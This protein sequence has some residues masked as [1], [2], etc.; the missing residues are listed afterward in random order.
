[1]SEITA[2]NLPAALEVVKWARANGLTAFYAPTGGGILPVT[3]RVL[4]GDAEQVA[5]LEK[6]I[7]QKE[8]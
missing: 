2:Q 3:H 8:G 1:M 7:T 4:V 6:M 5:A